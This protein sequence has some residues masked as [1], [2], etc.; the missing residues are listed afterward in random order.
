ME[1]SREAGGAVEGVGT[2]SSTGT[3][4]AQ[5]AQIIAM[6]AR[7]VKGIFGRSP[8]VYPA[9]C[10]ADLNAGPGRYSGHVG[11]PL[12]FLDAV[13]EIGLAH[14][15]WFFELSDANADELARNLLARR[16]TGGEL[17]IIRGDHH[18]TAAAVVAELRQIERDA[19]GLVY[20]DPTGSLLPIRVM[21]DLAEA[22]QVSRLDVLAY[23]S[24][25]TYKR[26]VGAHGGTR[27]LDDLRRVGKRFVWLRV[28][29]NH[30]QWTFAILTNWPGFPDLWKMGFRL[31]GTPEGDALA[32]RLNLTTAER[33]AAARPFRLIEPT[34]S[35]SGTRG[36]AKSARP[37]SGGRT[38]GASDAA[39][40]R[41]LSL[42]TS[43]TPDGEPST[44]RET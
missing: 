24:A 8:W 3:K 13:G 20:A 6:H 39:S 32:E 16:V 5:F 28:P 15:A 1:S 12:L 38:G 27:L 22:P 40:V 11:S 30:H 42:T 17:A 31:V 44:T 37:S 23:V 43:D 14:R 9:Y 18:E 29:E 41:Q 26:V 2:S 10:Y 36:S 25:T 35:T 4:Q 34:P 33:M 7:I 21:R 19:Y